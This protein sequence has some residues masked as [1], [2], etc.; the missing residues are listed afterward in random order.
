MQSAV[1]DRPRRSAHLHENTCMSTIH[2]MYH[3]VVR[4]AYSAKREVSIFALCLCTLAFFCFHA[5]VRP[6]GTSELPTHRARGFIP[7]K[8]PG[9]FEGSA[10]SGELFSMMQPKRPS[11]LRGETSLERDFFCMSQLR[12]WLE[13]KNGFK[14]G[15]CQLVGVVTT[16][17]E[18]SK[19]VRRFLNMPNGILKRC[20]LVIGD[21]KSP[22]VY[23]LQSADITVSEGENRETPA[24]FISAAEQTELGEM[25][26][27]VQ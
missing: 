8:D 23:D 18:P 16:I 17:F 4:R 13:K 15:S 1:Q 11:L 6:L 14:Q 21:Q 3:K 5:H 10:T 9:R 7:S 24:A 19:A 2:K 22:T 26:S 20:L 12:V 25:C 27:L